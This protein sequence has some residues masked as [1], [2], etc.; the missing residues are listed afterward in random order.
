MPKKCVLNIIRLK[1]TKQHCQSQ[2]YKSP[3]DVIYF[4]RAMTNS[5]QI[6]ISKVYFPKCIC[7]RVLLVRIFLQSVPGLRIFY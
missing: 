7:L 1:W 3:R 2:Q 5:F 4:L 6:L